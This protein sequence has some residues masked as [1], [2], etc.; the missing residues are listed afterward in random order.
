[1]RTKRN[2]GW[3]ALAVLLVVAG[4]CDYVAEVEAPIEQLE[5]RPVLQYEIAQLVPS[6]LE[7]RMQDVDEHFAE[8][9]TLA[10]VAL[11]LE[12]AEHSISPENGYAALARGARACAWLAEHSLTAADRKKYALRGMAF[13]FEAVERASTSVESYYYYAKNLAAFLRI[14][15]YERTDLIRSLHSHLLMAR[16]LDPGFD[17][18]GPDRE[19]AKFYAATRKLTSLGLGSLG[20]AED[21]LQSAIDQCSSFGAN[22]LVL[23]EIL[24]ERQDEGRARAVLDQLMDLPNPPDHA[25]EHQR[26]LARASELLGELP[27]L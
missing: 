25:V 4:G 20:K 18:C 8:P 13:G 6:A 5:R 7:R 21:L 11:S 24:I 23:A 26:W 2:D 12:T 1:M 3:M 14:K 9:R 27:G 16:Q 17:H 22:Y 10:G 15:N 19:L